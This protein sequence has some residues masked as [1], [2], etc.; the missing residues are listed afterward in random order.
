MGSKPGSR[1][2]AYA[3]IPVSSFLPWVPSCV[4]GIRVNKETNPFFPKMF[5][6]WVFI[7]AIESKTW[8]RKEHKY[9]YP[10]VSS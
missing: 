7:K 2:L 3:S 8:D 10:K 4:T 1:I 9:F 5:W 6:S